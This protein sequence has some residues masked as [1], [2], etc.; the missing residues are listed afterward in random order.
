MSSDNGWLEIS[1]PTKGWVS[2]NLTRVFCGS[3]FSRTTDYLTQLRQRGMQDDRAAIDLLIRYLYRG[4]DGAGGELASGFL[5]E[6]L[7]QRS[8]AISV[9]D[10]QS[11]EVRGKVLQGLQQVGFRPNDR[12][13]FTSKL[14]QNPNSPT[15]KTWAALRR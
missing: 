5:G 12:Q 9:L 2:L 3:E 13:T 15:A 14:S 10:S 8:T 4:T 7:V 6:L 11:E 1:R